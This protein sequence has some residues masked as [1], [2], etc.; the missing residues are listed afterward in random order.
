MTTFKEKNPFLFYL[1]RIRHVQ[2]ILSLGEVSWTS[3]EAEWEI[4]RVPN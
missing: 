4:S 3:R 2:L 1:R